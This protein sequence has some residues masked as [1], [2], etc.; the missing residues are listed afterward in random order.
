MKPPTDLFRRIFP[1]LRF[2]TLDC[3]GCHQ[4]FTIPYGP[5]EDPDELQRACR[6]KGPDDSVFCESCS[7]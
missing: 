5:D 3:S 6:G 4:P 2:L 7:Q 1:T